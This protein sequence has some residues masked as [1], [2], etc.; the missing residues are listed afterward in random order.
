MRP[1][2]R[3]TPTVLL[4]VALSSLGAVAGSTLAVA[5]PRPAA[6]HLKALPVH[7]HPG[8]SVRLHGSGFPKLTRVMLLAT[9]PHGARRQIGTARAG[10]DGSFDAPIQ[11]DPRSVSG[12]YVAVA[13]VSPCRVK[14]TAPFRVL[15]GR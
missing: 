15:R 9:P 14:A 1:R 3:R 10:S 11:V 5:Q 4:V 12:V 7:V 8:G 6:P 13:C 2:S